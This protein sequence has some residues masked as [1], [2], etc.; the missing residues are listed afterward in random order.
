[1]GYHV[2]SNG[3]LPFSATTPPPPG[4]GREAPLGAVP[5]SSL[6]RPGNRRAAPNGRKPHPLPNPPVK[7]KAPCPAPGNALR[8]EGLSISV[9]GKKKQGFLTGVG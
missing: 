9:A 5:A 2:T 4:G 1:M 8:H 3:V 7:I 6:R